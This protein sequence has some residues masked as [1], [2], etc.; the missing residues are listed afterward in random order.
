MRTILSRQNTESASGD[1]RPPTASRGPE[2]WEMTYEALFAAASTGNPLEIRRPV[3]MLMRNY[4]RGE[5]LSELSGWEQT[6][7]DID[8]ELAGGPT[9]PIPTVELSRAHRKVILAALAE[10]KPV[11]LDVLKDY[12]D[13]VPEY[14]CNRKRSGK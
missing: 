11:P 6:R 9:V 8:A 10:G 5:N 3:L 7:G 1:T 4:M 2:P 12:P 14:C 13:L